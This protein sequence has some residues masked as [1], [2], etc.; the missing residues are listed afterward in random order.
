[1]LFFILAGLME[2]DGGYLMW[3]WLRERWG[4]RVGTLGALVLALCADAALAA[5]RTTTIYVT[6]M[7]CAISIKQVL[8][9]T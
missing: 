4:W 5:T 6:G 3:L 2:I 9:N 8:K 7:T 1:M